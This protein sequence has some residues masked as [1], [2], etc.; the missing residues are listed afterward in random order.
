MEKRAEYLYEFFDVFINKAFKTLNECKELEK[1]S[2]NAFDIALNY[3]KSKNNKKVVEE[4]LEFGEN[5]KK[6][7]KLSLK[8]SKIHLELKEQVNPNNLAIKEEKRAFE[9]FKTKSDNLKQTLAYYY[10]FGNDDIKSLIDFC[11]ENIINETNT[12]K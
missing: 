7:Y 4:L 9:A 2:P 10:N 3:N 5:L 12:I 11:F 6:W 8:V 1:L